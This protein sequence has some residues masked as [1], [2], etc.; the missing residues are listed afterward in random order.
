MKKI[1]V[2]LIAASNN[3][4]DFV[5]RIA[6]GGSVAAPLFCKWYNPDFADEIIGIWAFVVAVLDHR[7]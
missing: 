7:F 2:A 5:K 3:P 4:P 1:V 6:I